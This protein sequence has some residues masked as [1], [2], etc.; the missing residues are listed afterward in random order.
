MFWHHVKGF[1]CI[2]SDPNN[3]PERGIIN[4]IN[5]RARIWILFNDLVLEVT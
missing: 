3:R 4:N 2:I 5:G 1:S